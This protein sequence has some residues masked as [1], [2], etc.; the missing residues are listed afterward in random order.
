MKSKVNEKIC[1][2]LPSFQKLSA[3]LWQCLA[4]SRNL[5]SSEWMNQGMNTGANELQMK[6]C[7]RPNLI[8]SK[9]CQPNEDCRLK[10]SHKK[11][12]TSEARAT[13]KPFNA[14]PC[15]GNLPLPPRIIW[16]KDIYVRM[17]QRCHNHLVINNHG[18]LWVGAFFPLRYT[19]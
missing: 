8:Y 16:D 15:K 5:L 3:S 19:S 10:G 11:I 9:S 13:Q 12:T 6:V 17:Q 7:F 2:E 14:T 18:L 4:N 1:D